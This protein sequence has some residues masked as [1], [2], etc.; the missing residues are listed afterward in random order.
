MPS[1]R[2]KGRRGPR[3]AKPARGSAPRLYVA[4]WRVHRDLTQ[5]ELAERIGVHQVTLARIE[6]GAEPKAGT[7][8]A[9]AAALR[10]TCEELLAEPGAEAGPPR[11]IPRRVAPEPPAPGAPPQRGRK[12]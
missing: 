8:F 7:L 9:L 4:A 5:E 10:T 3:R 2:E 1:F 6:G 12:P 11:R